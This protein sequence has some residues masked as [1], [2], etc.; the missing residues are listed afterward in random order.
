MGFP[1]HSILFVRFPDDFVNKE[2]KM[3]EM[4]VSPSSVTFWAVVVVAVE[5]L[6]VG[7]SGASPS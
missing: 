4:T 5:A 7:E 3:A 1:V 2:M 6:G